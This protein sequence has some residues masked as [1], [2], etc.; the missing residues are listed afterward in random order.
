MDARGCRGG[1]NW[2]LPRTTSSPPEDSR[3]RKE[4]ASWRQS[5]GDLRRP[6]NNPWNLIIFYCDSTPTS[7]LSARLS[8]TAGATKTN[9][10]RRLG[11]EIRISRY[12]W[13][14]PPPTSRSPACL[15]FPPSSCTFVFHL[16]L[17]RFLP[18]IFLF[19]FCLGEAITTDDRR[20]TRRRCTNCSALFNSSLLR[21]AKELDESEGNGRM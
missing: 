18:N 10:R 7:T 8:E 2:W 17:P 15:L 12:N 19:S 21:W 16:S 5:H 20:G 9:E 4:N 6:R 3:G 1:R 13:K 11:D 14:L